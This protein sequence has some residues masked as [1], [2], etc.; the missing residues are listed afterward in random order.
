M[1]AVQCP[2]RRDK[3]A[4]SVLY[5]C[6]RRVPLLSGKSVH[7]LAARAGLP[8]C[9]WF[10]YGCFFH[11]NV[12]SQ[13]KITI[14]F[15]PSDFGVKKTR[16]N[17]FLSWSCPCYTASCWAKEHRLNATTLLVLCTL[18]GYFPAAKADQSSSN[19]DH[20]DLQT[21]KDFHSDPIHKG[22]FPKLYCPVSW[23][24]FDLLDFWVCLVSDQSAQ[25]ELYEEPCIHILIFIHHLTSIPLS[26][27][28]ITEEIT[29]VFIESHGCLHGEKIGLLSKRQPEGPE[30]GVTTVDL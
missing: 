11:T 8:H 27:P 18:S 9:T 21:W 30:S 26:L 10:F 20:L 12:H 13:F 5:I 7:S 19:R 15:F 14:V 29:K 22:C 2:E 6:Q 1:W 28:G 24:N 23:P 4:V 25:M 17:V 16:G 3:E